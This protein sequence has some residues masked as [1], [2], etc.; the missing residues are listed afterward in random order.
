ML[1]ILN[2]VSHAS[3]NSKSEELKKWNYFFDLTVVKE[4]PE[5]N[6]FS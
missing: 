2:T 6:H 5:F 4:I 3:V 1:L